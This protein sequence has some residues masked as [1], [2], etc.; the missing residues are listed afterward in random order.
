[1]NENNEEIVVN[2]KKAIKKGLMISTIITFS[3]SLAFFIFTLIYI[4]DILDGDQLG[5][6]FGF[7]IFVVTVGWVTFLPA[8]GLAIASIIT[9]ANGLNSLDKKVK[10]TCLVFLILSIILLLSI[11]ALGVL[12]VLIPKLFI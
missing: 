5:K 12:V 7:A 9:A 1:M 4:L 2:E 10:K 11:V 6:A 3:L 8:L